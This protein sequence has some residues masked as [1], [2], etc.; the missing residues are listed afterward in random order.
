MLEKYFTYR[1]TVI[2]YSFLP[3]IGLS[4]ILLQKRKWTSN[5]LSY[6]DFFRGQGCPGGV[7]GMGGQ[8]L[9]QHG[10]SALISSFG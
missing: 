3:G 4:I 10:H 6:Q 1:N 8:E 5:M 2:I 7:Q 9:S